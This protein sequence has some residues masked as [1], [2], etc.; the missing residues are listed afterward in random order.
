MLH[1]EEISPLHAWSWVLFY[2]D[3]IVFLIVSYVSWVL[4]NIKDRQ[5]CHPIASRNSGCKAV[6][7]MVSPIFCKETNIY[8]LTPT[9]RHP[10]WGTDEG[11][12]KMIYSSRKKSTS[13]K[14]I[15]LFVNPEAHS[16]SLRRGVMCVAVSDMVYWKSSNRW[17]WGCS[18]S[19]LRK[20]YLRLKMGSNKSMPPRF[21]FEAVTHAKSNPKALCA[22]KMATY[23][24]LLSCMKNLVNRK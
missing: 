4:A 1:L 17:W 3:A 23:I 12:N 21:G 18:S 10:L 6:S 19:F 7:T 13:S 2:E 15:M 22:Y 20:S 14:N 24:N 11:R 8:L 16:W 9:F 5:E